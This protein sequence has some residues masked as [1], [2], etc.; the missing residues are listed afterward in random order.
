MNFIAKRN[1]EVVTLYLRIAH[2]ISADGLTRWTESEITDW[3]NQERLLHVGLPA[4]WIRDLNVT[5]ADMDNPQ[6]IAQI[7]GE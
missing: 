7:R 6:R 4:E 3:L 1:I 2:N 5:V